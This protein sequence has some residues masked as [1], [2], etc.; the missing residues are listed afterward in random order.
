M[1][2]FKYFS[3][4]NYINK[5]KRVLVMDGIKQDERL[6]TETEVSKYLHISV[7]TLRCWR[8]KHNQCGKLPFIKIG[9][10]LVRYRKSEIDD[11]L[12]QNNT[13]GI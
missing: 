5:Y 1:A 3:V 12:K 7:D 2:T 13:T 10:K 9:G 4:I 8:K 6:L 11:F